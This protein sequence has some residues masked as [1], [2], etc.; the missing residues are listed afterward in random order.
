MINQFTTT[1]GIFSILAF[2]V[3]FLLLV[4]TYQYIR[5]TARKREVLRKI[6]YDHE[7]RVPRREEGQFS[8]PGNRVRPL[9][10]RFLGLLGRKGGTDNADYSGMR[11]KFLRAGLRGENLAA[12]F[13]GAKILLA[14]GMAVCFLA[15]RISI[16]PGLSLLASL[17]AGLYLALFGFYLPDIWLRIRTARRRK[18]IF[19]GLPDALD[20]LVVC[21][22]AGMG[23][24]AAITRVGEEIRFTD[25]ELSDELRL[26]NLEL[27]AGKT[28]QEALKNLA[29]RV[30][31]EDM[32][33]LVTLLVQTDKFGTSIAQALRVYSETFRTKR[34]QAAEELAA[35]LPVKL[36]F[37]LIFFIFPAI[38]VVIL[39]PAVIQIFHTLFAGNAL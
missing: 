37:P 13:W 33:S 12:V 34:Y 38:F 36:L 1:P 8:E 32:N 11:V 30:N 29:R 10:V 31:L 27:R 35:K 22:E 5:Q 28:R 15:V 3:I 39:G 26:L 4:G 16:L 21:V 23:L 19:N 24:D 7:T 2:L 25:R 20:L 6:R 17:G 14:V 18:K 9:L